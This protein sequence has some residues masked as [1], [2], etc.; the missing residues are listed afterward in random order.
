MATGGSI[1]AVSI[2]GRTFPATSDADSNR[3][4]GGFEVEVQANGDGTARVVKTRVPWMVDGVSLEIDDNRGDQE[5]LQEV[6]DGERGEDVP[7]TITYADG[8]TYQGRGLPSGEIQKASMN[9]TGSVTFSG[10]GKLT[11]Q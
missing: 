8:N 4:L 10:P 6:A 11:K 5:F 9:A 2:D 7:I 3:K 1:E